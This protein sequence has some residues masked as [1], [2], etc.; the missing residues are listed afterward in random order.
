MGFMQARA[1]RFEMLVVETTAGTEQVPL[2]LVG[3]AGDPKD[4][5]DYVEGTVLLDS[6]GAPD[7]VVEDGWWA[8]FTAPGYLDCTSWVGPYETET[9][10]LEALAESYGVCGGCFEPCWE[11][12]PCERIAS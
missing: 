6:D 2:D 12:Q 1:E 3:E 7:T 4:L 9:E 11:E 8:R 10:A 5:H